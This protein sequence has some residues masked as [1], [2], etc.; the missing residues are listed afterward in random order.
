MQKEQRDLIERVRDEVTGLRE[1]KK[2]LISKIKD[3]STQNERH[4]G[5]IHELE[6]TVGELQGRLIDIEKM[7]G[8]V[9][10]IK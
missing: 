6:Q 2:E 3:L 8:D 7:L 10:K 5:N 4:V 1:Q 9:L